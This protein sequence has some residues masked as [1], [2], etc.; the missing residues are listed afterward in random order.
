MSDRPYVL[1]SCAM[2]VD[3][4]LDD[5]S[6]ERLI[7]SN[8]DDLDRVDELRARCDAILVGANTIR[9]DDPR[10]LVRSDVRRL[11]RVAEGLPPSPL[12]VT[13]TRS[14]ELSPGARFFAGEAESVVFSSLSEAL[15]ALVERGVRRLLVEGG[16][17]VLTSLFAADLV[18]E[19]QLAVAPFFVGDA[20]APRFV[21]PG[22][23][24]HSARR[25]MR[26]AG[27]E[28]VGDVVVLRYLLGAMDDERW[29]RE[30]IEH[31]RLCPPSRTAFSVGAIVV[32]ASGEEL[33]RGYSR[34]G[35]PLNHAEEAAL[36][37][38]SGDLSGA[39]I[40][41]SLEPCSTRKSRER[42]CADHIEAAGLRRVVFAWRE[43]S[44]FVTG[45]GAERLTAAGID[46]VELPALA[47]NVREVNA[48]LF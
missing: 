1:V 12:R 46:V 32:S 2:S 6:A 7:L 23:F 34:E 24:P 31:S 40:Y 3:G 20:L 17:A 5:A 30:A 14:G 13:V 27:V 41:S 21:G 8:S 19:L 42:S 33:A 18:D 36:A 48:H 4:F 47:P 16:S 44:L 11:A 10:L 15:P 9:R 38:L 35:D 39:T 28:Q 22:A 43:P 37:K 26:L 29:L 25:R 45:E